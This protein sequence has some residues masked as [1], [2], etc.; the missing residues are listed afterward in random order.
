MCLDKQGRAG[1]MTAGLGLEEVCGVQGW[2]PAVGLGLAMGRHV[3]GC[4]G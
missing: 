2:M 3:H 4:R 1:Q